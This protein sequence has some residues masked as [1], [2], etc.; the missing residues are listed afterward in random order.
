MKN[1]RSLATGCRS[2]ARIVFLALAGLGVVSTASRAQTIPVKVLTELKKATVLIKTEAG[3]IGGSGTGFVMK[4][5]GTVGYIVTNHHVVVLPEELVGGP[6][7]TRIRAVFNSGSRLE[8]TYEAEIVAADDDRDLA[9]L[10]TPTLNLAYWNLEGRALAR[11]RTGWTVDGHPLTFFHFSGFDPRRPLTLSKHQNRVKAEAG[12]PLAR[13]L[14]DYAEA[15]LRNGHEAASAVPYA[16]SRFATGR[17][18][19]PLMR[20]T[21]LAAGRRG[22]TFETGLDQDASAW[23]DQASPEAAAAGLPDVTRLMDQ[24][25]RESP[26]ADPFD[27]DSRDGRLAFHRWFV[28]NAGALGAD[29]ASLDAARALL[30]PGSTRVAV[31]NDRTAD[32]QQ[33]F[34]AGLRELS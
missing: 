5:E 20:R 2:V 33:A 28:D 3:D 16:H 34:R 9:I 18:V 4:V 22:T 30:D 11:T 7:R 29:A 19:T 23:F 10:R 13:L 26:G 15:M 12:S 31:I 14:A 1:D 24:A 27:R 25:W 6:V 8:R 21:A 32:L 17:T